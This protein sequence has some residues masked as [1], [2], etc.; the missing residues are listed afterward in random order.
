VPEGIARSLPYPRS[1]KS[2]SARTLTLARRVVA[3][4]KVY[5]LR[6][7][8]GG[9]PKATD[10]DWRNSPRPSRSTRLPSFAVARSA[11]TSVRERRPLARARTCRVAERRRLAPRPVGVSPFRSRKTSR[12][13]SSATVCANATPVGDVARGAA[14]CSERC[15]K[16]V[17][18]S[19]SV[20]VRTARCFSGLTK[21][22]AA[23]RDAFSP[24]PGWYRSRS[25]TALWLLELV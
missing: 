4:P 1:G 13:E 19:R 7:S 24:P 3:V 18:P 8:Y 22:R 9:D 5:H 12:S 16:P 17:R 25:E 15:R 20:R 6:N 2:P 21:V 10:H 11:P 14:S 23:K